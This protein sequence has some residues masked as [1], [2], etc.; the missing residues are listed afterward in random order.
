MP[1]P[2]D[3]LTPDDTLVQEDII[4]T[5]F[6]AP[7]RKNKVFMNDFDLPPK[8][9]L[10]PK[11]ILEWEDDIINTF[12]DVT[13]PSIHGISPKDETLMRSYNPPK[14]YFIHVER[15]NNPIHDVSNGE[16]EL[17]RNLT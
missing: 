14:I 6:K 7:S 4:N 12:L 9:S 2:K 10:S 13:L 3:P 16:E 17:K 5:Y 1:F 8:M 15:L 11:D